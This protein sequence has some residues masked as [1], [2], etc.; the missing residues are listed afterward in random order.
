MGALG[1]SV[2]LLDIFGVWPIRDFITSFTYVCGCQVETYNLCQ[3]LTY[4]ID[5]ST[6]QNE[7]FYGA[8]YGHLFVSTY[9]HIKIGQDLKALQ[10]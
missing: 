4:S 10:P 2:W 5:R 6:R 8:L 9:L 1:G 7:K 3:Y